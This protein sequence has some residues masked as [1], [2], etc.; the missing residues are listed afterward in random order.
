[1]KF[2]IKTFLA[3]VATATITNIAYSQTPYDDFAPSETK[4]EMLKLPNSSFTAINSDTSSKV[5]FVE[6]NIDEFSLSYLDLNKELIQ[7]VALKPTDLKW[8]SVDP[9]AEK[10]QSWSPYNYCLNNPIINTDPN[11]DT[12]RVYTESSSNFGLGHAWIS[13]G[14]GKDMTVFTFGRYA[15]TYDEWHG[16][17]AISNG[18]GVLVKLDGS[19]ATEYNAQKMEN[20]ATSIF[21]VVDVTD[22]DVFKALNNKFMSSTQMPST[23]EYKNNPAAHII[24]DYKLTS[25]NCATTVSDALNQTGS[26]AM[27]RMPNP[28][29]GET[30][31][32]R[33]VIPAS[34]GSFLDWQSNSWLGNNSVLY[35][36]QTQPKK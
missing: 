31:N 24:G 4:K 6:L 8:W 27:Q 34:L 33:F 13:V 23:G 21:K 32:D 1:M 19:A 20:Y 35:G 12:V 26:D 29:T 30:Y 7:K 36:G 25:E 9:R 3:I 17:N 5:R 16:I 22:A 10:Y 15:G 14:E 28:K 11:G 18:P 2:K